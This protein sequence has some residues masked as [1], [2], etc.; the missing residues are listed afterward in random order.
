[1]RAQSY[2][3]AA[4]ADD[5]LSGSSRP[6]QA[7]EEYPP[8]P[9]RRWRDLR[10]RRLLLILGV[11]I[12]LPVSCA[13]GIYKG[14]G[15]PICGLAIVACL[16][17]WLRSWK[18]PAC[19]R[20]FAGGF[21]SLFPQSCNSCGILQFAPSTAPDMFSKTSG[22]GI[23]MRLL[24]TRTI[25]AVQLLGGCLM[26]IQ[27]FRLFVALHGSANVLVALSESLAAVGV[28]GGVELWRQRARGYG[29][30]LVAQGIQILRFHYGTVLFRAALGPALVAGLGPQGPYGFA[31]FGLASVVSFNA[32][33]DPFLEVNVAALFICILVAR[34]RSSTI[35]FRSGQPVR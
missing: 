20:M 27:T 6:A 32:T 30:S 18:C 21:T 19:D 22:T 24:L 10:E 4:M 34:L 29:L 17:A 8:I 11:G 16:A 3:F 35:G 26:A 9:G 7:N 2:S 28:Y 12:A 14:F 13:V 25:A 31:G 33:G 1:M 15:V 23:S 5:K